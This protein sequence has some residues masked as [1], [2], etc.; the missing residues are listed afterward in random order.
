MTRCLEESQKGPKHAEPYV[1][2]SNARASA[3]LRESVGGPSLQNHLQSRPPGDNAEA[4]KFLLTA[5]D[6][7]RS[8]PEHIICWEA[9]KSRTVGQRR[10][11]TGY[12]SKI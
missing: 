4:E 5:A 2:R 6:L 12:C 11:G 1:L 10:S 3:V 7:T 9:V 8:L